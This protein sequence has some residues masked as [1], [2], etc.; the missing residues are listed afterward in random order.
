MNI[1]L[2][3]ALCLVAGSELFAACID[4]KDCPDLRHFRPEPYLRVV[5][6]LQSIPKDEAISLIRKWSAQP[7]YNE[8]IVILCRMLFEAEDRSQ[9]RRPGLGGAQFFGATTYDDWPLEPI[10][11]VNDIPFKI[12]FG[13]ILAGVAESGSTYFQHCVTKGKWTSRRYHIATTAEIQKAFDQLTDSKVWKKP[14]SDWEVR[15]LKKQI[16]G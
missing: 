15:E 2:A 3:I 5:L 8:Q 14:L 11:L 6:A 1:R 9:F 13:Y 12:V 7:D 4:I 16:H 10:A